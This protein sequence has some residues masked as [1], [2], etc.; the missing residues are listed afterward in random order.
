MR[1]ALG[2]TAWQIHR[3]TPFDRLRDTQDAN[4]VWR[5]PK[6]WR[7]KP[8]AFPVTVHL[9]KIR[10]GPHSL[11][12]LDQRICQGVYEKRGETNGMRAM[13]RGESEDCDDQGREKVKRESSV[14][15]G[16]G[17]MPSPPHESESVERTECRVQERRCAS[18]NSQPVARLERN[19]A[20]RDSEMKNR[21]GFTSFRRVDARQA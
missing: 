4:T 7:R 14:K 21:S 8:R 17:L 18:E 16:M 15:K 2:D 6:L 20:G 13:S 19:G 11:T 10:A 9:P 1:L 12:H 5:A 3:E